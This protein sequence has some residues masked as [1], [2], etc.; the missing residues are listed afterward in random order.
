MFL[1]TPL[2]KKKRKNN[3]TTSGINKIANEI[4]QPNRT[5]TLP[6]PPEPDDVD[7]FLI[8]MG[9][10][11]KKLT[12]LKKIEVMQKFLK[13]TYDALAESEKK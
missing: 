8:S 5:T 3:D 12:T 13:I 6:P 1:D 4:C 11:L 2:R 10:H 9:H 7:S